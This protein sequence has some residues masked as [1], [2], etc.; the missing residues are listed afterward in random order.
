MPDNVQLKI[1]SIF[2][3]LFSAIF[4]NNNLFAAEYKIGVRAHNGIKVA[5]EMWQPTAK[6]LSQKIPEHIFKLVPV[7]GLNE[8]NLA[9]KNNKFDFVLTNPSSYIELST[10]SG[11]T[12]FATL[13][14]KRANT[15]Q[16][17][18]GSVIFIHASNDNILSLKDL[19]GKTV[20]AVAKSA[21]GGWYVAWRE[22]RKQG[23]DPFRN[24]KAILYAKNS[25]QKEVVYAVRDGK[26]DAG[27]VRTDQLE[28][29]ESTG[30]IDMRN[31]R[32]LNN[33]DVKGFPFFLSTDLYPEW[34]FAAMKNTPVKV[35]QQVQKNLY[36]MP[37]NSLAAMKGQYIGWLPEK[38]YHPVEQLMK[39][40]KVG[41]YSTENK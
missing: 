12:A 40:L 25:L 21:F 28:R 17:Q 41:P 34:A 19:R 15:A 9:A 6:Y 2:L 13:N 39:E 29:M 7:E 35:V 36:S 37:K 31:F 30:E 18:F 20:M 11:A 14:N 8:L 26:V 16:S 23:V 33:K 5:Y 3:L 38:D 10:Y 32:I 24:F 4:L 1:N 22:F 27:V